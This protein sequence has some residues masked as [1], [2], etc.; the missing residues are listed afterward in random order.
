MVEDKARD[1]S[2]E[3]HMDAVVH[4][5]ANVMMD[6]DTLQNILETMVNA[7]FVVHQDG[8]VQRANQAACTLLGFE[9]AAL[10]GKSMDE[11]LVDGKNWQRGVA[12]RVDRE[13]SIR[14]AHYSMRSCSGEEVPV[15]FSASALCD[16]HGWSEGLVCAAQDI[17]E[18]MRLLQDLRQSQESFFS[19]V[20]KSADGILIVDRE[21]MVSFVNPAAERL[22]ARPASQLVGISFG[23]PIINDNAMEVD[24]VRPDGDFGIAEMRSTD[25]VWGRQEAY[26]V[27]LRDVTETV[28]MREELR[29][30]SMMDEL[31]GLNNRRS[32]LLHARHERL[33][34]KREGGMFSLLF[35]DMDGMKEINDKLGHKAGDLALLETAEILRAVF[36]E[37]D[38]LAR[39]GGDEFLVL[40]LSHTV[41]G[42][43]AFMLDRLAEEVE[44]HNKAPGRQ[45]SISLSVG[46]V[47]FAAADSRD[48]DAIIEEADAVMYQ[49]KTRKKKH[50]VSCVNAVHTAAP[51]VSP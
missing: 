40:T 4:T 41:K 35:I 33:T 43:Q 17:R 45:F 2:A 46:G 44:R 42:H 12:L 38:I 30:L 18:H 5:L 3:A 36:R 20:E 7:V 34:A 49:N 28:R 47:D 13:G 31:T 1:S 10:V 19:I 15:L 25:T 27:T 21:G 8:R 22:L 37:S 14:N 51:G 50:W 32:F 11:L 24:V 6:R 29:M 26:L 39:I 9:L 48:L 16:R 23:Y